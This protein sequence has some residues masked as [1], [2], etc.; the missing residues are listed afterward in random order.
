MDTTNKENEIFRYSS[1]EEM[2][3]VNPTKYVNPTKDDFDQLVSQYA[4]ALN[5]LGCYYDKKK[6][7]QTALEC[8]KLSYK[9]GCNVAR[10]N[11]ADLLSTVELDDEVSESMRYD[12][13]IKL[14]EK[15]ILTIPEDP[16]GYMALGDVYGKK[17]EYDKKHEYYL[18]AFHRGKYGLLP[19]ILWNVKDPIE[20]TRL[21]D[22]LYDLIIVHNDV[23]NLDTINRL[24][25]IYSDGNHGVPV[26]H[27]KS[28]ILWE[29]AAKQDFGTSV[30]N[31]G[32]C[33]SY[34]E[35]D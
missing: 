11:F 19:R 13:C 1:L 23:V 32:F 22:F 12:K 34:G 14:F 3:I 29:I 7:K 10:F 18:K 9:K 2:S 6:E 27:V 30:Y 20:S 4:G 21:V 24:G 25:L 5:L 35:G 16:D 15:Y 33:Y 26:N 17:G 31:L 8:Y 28:F